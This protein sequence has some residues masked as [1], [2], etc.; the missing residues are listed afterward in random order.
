MTDG[1]DKREAV[2]VRLLAIAV[3]IEDAESSRNAALLDTSDQRRIS[4]LEG[5][6]E[7]NED[8]GNHEPDDKGIVVMIPQFL[9][10][11]GARTRDVGTDLNRFR[12]R[13]IK[14]VLG[15]S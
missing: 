4:V 12:S 6:E 7:V 1:V 11:C 14:A 8:F 2:M 10:S 13:L 15:D 3:G 9:I 5:D